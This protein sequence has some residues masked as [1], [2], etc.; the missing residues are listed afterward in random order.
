MV[1]NWLKIFRHR[2]LIQTEEQ[3]YHHINSYYWEVTYEN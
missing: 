1:A 3:G 2:T